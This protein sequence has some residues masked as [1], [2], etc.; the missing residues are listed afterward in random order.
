M[1][2]YEQ[3]RLYY[4]SQWGWL[5]LLSKHV[6]LSHLKWLSENSN[7]SASNF[8]L[9]LNIS[10]RKLF[11]WFRRPSNGQLVIR[12]F[13]M[14]VCPLSCRVF[15]KTSN[16]A[17]DSDPYSPHLVL[18][19]FRLFPKLK[20]PLKG[21]R[22]QTVDEIQE[23]TTGQLR[24]LGKPC[25]VPRCLLWRGLRCHCSMYNVSCTLSLL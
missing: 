8:T 17:G 10:P 3:W 5:T 23:N 14:T 12:N 7:K 6:W 19:D 2:L 21:K 18:C 4:T 20:S 1:C 9:T 13:N 22:F 24:R 16:H 25:E 11:E 15:C